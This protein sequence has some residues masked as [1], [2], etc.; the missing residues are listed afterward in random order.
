[1][2]TLIQKITHLESVLNLPHDN[3]A[4]SFKTDILFFFDEF[5]PTNPKLKFLEKLSSTIEIEQWLTKLT[6]R[7]TLKFDQETEQL[8]DFI[9]DYLENS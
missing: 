6:S 4:D 1:M 5:D 3:Y 8:S 9:Y 2:L 7:I